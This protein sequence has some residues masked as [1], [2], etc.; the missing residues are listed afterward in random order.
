MD[1]PRAA[2]LTDRAPLPCGHFRLQVWRRLPS[3]RDELLELMDEPNLVVIG[4]RAVLA[5]LLGGQTTPVNRIGFGAG[6]APAAFGN[7]AL[8]TP[9]LKPVDSVS[10]PPTAGIVTFGFSLA[11]TEANGLAIGEFGLLTQAGTLFARKARLSSPIPKDSTLSLAGTWSVS[12]A[13]P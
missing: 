9:F 11:S 2:G 13:G 1:E 3:G 12:F 10:Y 4:A 8:T 6:T 5:G 7:T